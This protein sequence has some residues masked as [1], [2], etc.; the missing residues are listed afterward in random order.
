[1]LQSL[2]WDDEVREADFPLPKDDVR[3]SPQE[4][5]MASSLVDNMAADFAPDKFSDE[6]QDQLRQLIAAK[7][8]KGDAVDTAATFGEEGEEQADRG[9]VVDLME[10]RRSVEQNRAA[11]KATRPSPQPRRLRRKRLRRRRRRPTKPR[12]RRHR[13]RRRRQRSQPKR[14]VDLLTRGRTPRRRT[15]GYRSWHCLDRDRRDPA[16]CAQHQHSIRVD[17]TL[18]IIL[19]VA[20]ALALILALVMQAQ[21]SRTRHVRRGATTVL[22][23]SSK[24]PTLSASQSAITPWDADKSGFSRGRRSSGHQNHLGAQAAA[25]PDHITIELIGS[26]CETY[27]DLERPATGRRGHQYASGG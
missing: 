18:G 8:E 24:P 26:G 4:L 13:P 12:P 10:A 25:I 16:L 17:D 3:V 20:G 5:K 27:F 11:R 19:I 14:P 15:H 21:R 6:Y 23:Q 9:E 2:L 1:M 7:L 22:R